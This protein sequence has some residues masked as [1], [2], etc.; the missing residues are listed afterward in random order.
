MN[1]VRLLVFLKLSAD[2][3]TAH[4]SDLDDDTGEDQTHS[5]T[6]VEDNVNLSPGDANASDGQLLFT[7]Y[8]MAGQ[9]I[10]YDLL[11]LLLSRCHQWCPLICKVW[12]VRRLLQYGGNA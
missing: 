10:F 12:C 7:I 6:V 11:Q 4:K 2:F 9:P 5:F 8:D 1:Q 3:A